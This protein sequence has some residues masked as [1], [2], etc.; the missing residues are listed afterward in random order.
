[1]KPLSCVKCQ[2]ALPG[3]PEVNPWEV[4]CPECRSEHRIH[5]FPA[6]QRVA[7]PAAG[8]PT[9]ILNEG[10]ASCFYH[11][12]KQAALVCDE[13][14]RFLCKLC[15]IE[16]LGRHLCPACLELVTQREQTASIQKRQVLH[17]QI[18]ISIALVPLLV[19]PVTCLTCWVVFY[20]C[21]RYWDAPNG[22]QSSNKRGYV[23]AMVFAA[24][25]AIGWLAF[26]L[27]VIGG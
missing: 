25:E 1:M 17:G 23:I 8:R 18:A 21:Y 15:D 4:T 7:D 5:L 10:E 20:Y 26:G 24:L 16:L 27:S 3:L 2:T 22:L 11:P 19:W 14:G 13:C 12:G 6:Y 9:S